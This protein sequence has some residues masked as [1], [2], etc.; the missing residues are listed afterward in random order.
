[1]SETEAGHPKAARA[2]RERP[3]QLAAGAGARCAALWKA[4]VRGPAFER[5]R[6]GGSWEKCPRVFVREARG[7]SQGA[8][9]ESRVSISTECNKPLASFLC[10]TPA[11]Y[12]ANVYSM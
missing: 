12:Q 7:C 2:G 11:E 1:M 9:A 4:G 10:L 5:L 8:V 6:P 3:Q